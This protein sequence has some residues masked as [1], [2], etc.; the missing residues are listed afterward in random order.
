MDVGGLRQWAGFSGPLRGGG[1]PAAAWPPYGINHLVEA[2]TASYV[3]RALGLAAAIGVSV[4]AYFASASVLR[5]QE[6]GEA[7]RMVRRRIPGL[8]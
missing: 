7:W 3:L 8:A 2:A 1:W 4:P 6:S 5:L